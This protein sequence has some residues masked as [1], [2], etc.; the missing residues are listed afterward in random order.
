MFMYKKD[1]SKSRICFEQITGRLLQICFK[2]KGP[3]LVITNTL[4]PHAWISGDRSKDDMLEIRQ[5]VFQHYT[6]LLLE[7]KEKCFHLA[8][9]DV[10]TRLHARG[11][12]EERIIGPFVWGRGRQFIQKM[13][14]IDKEQ[15]GVLVA[16]LK[17][18][19]HIHMN[20][21]FEKCDEKKGTT[22][23]TD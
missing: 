23:R 20:S 21:F 18:T 1:L 22:V 10:N 7:N 14:P 15:R 13:T 3:N 4:A 8:V 6:E 5:E 16:A 12:G 2:T 9:G 19:D 11:R 17:A